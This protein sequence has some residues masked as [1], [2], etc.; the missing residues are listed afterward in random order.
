MRPALDGHAGIPQ[1]TRLLFRLLCALDA[2]EVQGLLQTSLRFLTAGMPGPRHPGSPDRDES[3]R[4][5]RYARLLVSLENR[6]PTT[7]FDVVDQYLRRRRVAWGLALA[8]LVFPP[9]GRIRSSWFEPRGFE[10]SVW[11]SLFAKTLPPED[12]NLVTTRSFRVVTTPWNTMQSAGLDARRL[13]GRTVYP[14]LDTRGVDVLIAQTP[15]PARVSAGTALVVRYHDALP[16]LM[17]NAF[18]NRERHLAT[19]FHALDSNVKSGAFFA[20]VSESTRQGLL[21]IFPG[22]GDRAVTIH[23]IVS[24]HYFPEDSASTRVPQIVRTRLNAKLADTQPRFRSL[25]EQDGFYERHI[26]SGPLNYLLMVSSIEPRK[27]HAQLITAWAAIRGQTDPTLKLVIV[28]SASWD[29]AQTLDSMRT[30]IDQGAL[31]VLANVPASELRVLYRH[32]AATVCPSL[33]EGFDFS[34]VEAMRSGG[35]VIASDIAVH[36][37]VYADAAEYFDLHST[38]GLVHV[39]HDVLYAAGAS[40]RQ[41]Q[42][43]VRGQVVASRYLPGAILPRWEQ[44]LNRLR[45]LDAS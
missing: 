40:P 6:A 2:V 5:H 3:V 42:L 19:H 43:R 37:E 18:A 39:L 15:Y 32:A 12:F 11:Q 36:R 44:L 20:C 29:A 27:N 31:V 9:L 35:V 8:A 22:L 7:R 26:G 38:E 16:I 17:P 34:G 30:W 23:N 24:P 45:P 1:E 28:G 33:A 13:S 14:A 25:D 10:Q 21:R 41:D 4:M